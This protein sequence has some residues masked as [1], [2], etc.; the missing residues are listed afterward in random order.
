MTFYSTPGISDPKK[1]GGFNPVTPRYLE[2][3]AF[4]NQILMLYPDTIETQSFEMNKVCENLDTY[5][6]FKQRLDFYLSSNVDINLYK[7]ILSRHY[8]SQRVE[9]FCRIIK[10]NL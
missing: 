7:Q 6:K 3:L 9:E 4:Q 5:D 8:T 1:T 2:M 10:N